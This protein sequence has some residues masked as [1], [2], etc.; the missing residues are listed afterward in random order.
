MRILSL[1]AVFASLSNSLQSAA[2]TVGYPQHP[3]PLR[4]RKFFSWRSSATDTDRVPRCEGYSIRDSWSLVVLGD[5]HLE[6][7]MTVHEQA[8]EDCITAMKNLSLIPTHTDGVRLHSDDTTTI[9]SVREMISQLENCRAGDLSA[10]QLEMLMN[11]KRDGDLMKC[12]LVSLGDLGRKDIR[13]EPGDAGTTKSFLDAKEFLD[14]FSVPYELVSGNHDLEGLDEFDTDEGNLQGWLKAFSKS[15]PHF[16]RQIGERTILVGL[17][18]VRFR[19]A[20]FS[21]HE[22]HIDDD[23]L[24]WFVRTV[25]AHPAK[26]GWK[27]IVFSHAPIVG[28]GLRVLQN[29][30]VTNGCAW[31]NHC[32][33]NRNAFIR[34]VVQNPQVKLWFSG[35]FH[36]SHDFEDAISSV[37]SCTFV[38]VGVIGPASTRDGRR[39]TRLVQGSGDRMRIFTIN[40]H[41]RDQ[42]NHAVVRLDAD[43]DVLSGKVAVELDNEKIDR[44]DWFQAYVPRAED[45]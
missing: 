34:T 40:H 20:P 17:S 36:L 26:D 12:F 19:D 18:T 14:G 5:L 10:A 28:S 37:G 3:Q 16:C 21:S 43:I 29:V 45:G 27:V 33:S 41:L 11:S 44:E 35:H 7:D 42:S 9:P 30:H 4:S 6:D 2:F 24:D 31:L 38:Q 23:Q 15:T 22:V 32:S 39:Q 25:E 8:R 1:V 13:H